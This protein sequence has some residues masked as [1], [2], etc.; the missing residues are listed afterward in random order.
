MPPSALMSP[1]AVSRASNVRLADD[2][3]RG[4]RHVA[5]RPA[6]SCC[7]AG[8]LPSVLPDAESLAFLVFLEEIKPGNFAIVPA[9]GSLIPGSHW[10]RA[11]FA[12]G[13]PAKFCAHEPD[14]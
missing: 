9:D 11:F 2:P 12:R 10:D 14:T 4:R 7:R 1:N 3:T 13:D 6:S 5:D 8:P